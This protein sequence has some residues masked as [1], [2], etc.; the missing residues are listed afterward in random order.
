VSG[1]ALSALAVGA[2]AAPGGAPEPWL[3]VEPSAA[4]SW[5]CR[6]RLGLPSADVPATTADTTT[7]DPVANP[8]VLDARLRDR[9]NR[10]PA[11]FHPEP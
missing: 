11:A 7:A 4:S 10:I 3:R 9:L 2:L 1:L 6:P 5:R 8:A